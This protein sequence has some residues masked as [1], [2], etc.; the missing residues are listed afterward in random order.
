MSYIC[1]QCGKLHEGIP[2]SFAADFPDQYA[3]MSSED[4]D[5]RSTIASD[6][7]IIDSEL[8]YVR[9]LLEVPVLD[10]D[11]VFLWG[12]WANVKEEVFDELDESWE[13]HGRETRHGPFKARLANKLAVYPD[14]L[15]LKM[16]VQIQP[17]GQRPLFFIDEEAHPLA[18]AQR[19]GMS[20]NETHEL[21]S[22][23]LHPNL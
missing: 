15:N 14:T 16:T 3:N 12:L 19:M 9:G 6:Q 2:L 8:F 13:E 4:R 22:R 11:E 23:L 7:C 5:T 21:V 17:V 10:S 20:A 18:V 1:H